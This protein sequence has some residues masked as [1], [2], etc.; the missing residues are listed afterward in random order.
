MFLPQDPL[1]SSL[2]PD[3]S[4][5]QYAGSIVFPAKPGTNPAEFGKIAGNP[6]HPASILMLLRHARGRLLPV[7]SI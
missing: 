5:E 7:S 1:E 2:Y 3:G 4:L 6:R